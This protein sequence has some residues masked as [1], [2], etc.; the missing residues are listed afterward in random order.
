MWVNGFINWKSNNLIPHRFLIK[1]GK[2][3]EVENEN[4]KGIKAFENNSSLADN[5]EILKTYKRD[6][7]NNYSRYYIK[8]SIDNE[9]F[10]MYLKINILQYWKLKWQLKEWLIQS[11]DFKL[12]ILK[13][14][15]IGIL[16][17]L[18]GRLT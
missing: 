10:L 11:K 9:V 15:A 14:I 12:E 6:I 17:Y 7:S 5:I 16:A 18:I 8:K 1:Y 2:I 13:Y 4:F 3:Q